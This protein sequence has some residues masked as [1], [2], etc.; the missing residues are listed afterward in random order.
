MEHKIEAILELICGMN[1]FAQATQIKQ[2]KVYH[3]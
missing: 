1:S 3:P 2:E